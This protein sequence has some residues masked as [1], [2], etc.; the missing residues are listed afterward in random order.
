MMTL[1]FGVK[2]ILYVKFPT[3]FEH[4]N[5]VRSEVEMLFYECQPFQKFKCSLLSSFTSVFPH[6]DTKKACCQ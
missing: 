4:N 6:R 1:N 5:A 2:L 3:Y